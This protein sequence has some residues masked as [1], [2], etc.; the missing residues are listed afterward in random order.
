[1]HKGL[2]WWIICINNCK[3]PPKMGWRGARRTRKA[4]RRKNM[5]PGHRCWRHINQNKSQYKTRIPLAFALITET[6]ARLIV[7]YIL[8]KPNLTWA[9]AAHRALKLDMKIVWLKLP[10]GYAETAHRQWA[11][12]IATMPTRGCE[13]VSLTVHVAPLNDYE[14]LPAAR[15]QPDN[16][17]QRIHKSIK[18]I[19][20]I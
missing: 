7:L 11:A 8:M 17:R 6:G 1:M 4:R 10:V 9:I 18:E 20:L 14:L 16:D 13:R 15:E 5:C 12:S 3:K 2:R 19:N